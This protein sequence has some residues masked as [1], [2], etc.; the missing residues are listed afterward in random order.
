FPDHELER[1]GPIVSSDGQDEWLI[2]QI[3]NEH[4]R[5]GKQQFKVCWQG[6][7]P[8]DDDWLDHADI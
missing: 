2:E 1:P 5:R 6:Y 4:T 3:I 8:E 7:G